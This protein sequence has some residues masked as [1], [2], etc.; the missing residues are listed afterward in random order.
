MSTP[1]SRVY[2]FADVRFDAATGELS[3]DGVHQRLARQPARA[4]EL[5]LER[6][7]ELVTR[8]EMVRAVWAEGT[9]VDF[10]QCL[11]YCVREIR[12]SLGDSARGSRFVE[13]LPKRGYRFLVPVTRE[14]A[15]GASDPPVTA[16]APAPPPVTRPVASRRFQRAGVLVAVALGSLAAGA[17]L[18]H[19]VARSPAHDR[20]VAWV[21]ELLGVAGDSCLWGGP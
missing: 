18:G 21:H 16:G 11:G 19:D 7:G 17:A 1:A 2:R 8:D 3:R 9:H 10:D 14:G 20:A 13:T 15:A 12:R 4:F 6:A 5:L